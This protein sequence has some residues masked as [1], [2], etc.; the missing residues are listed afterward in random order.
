[1]NAGAYTHLNYTNGSLQELE[2]SADAHTFM[3]QTDVS[4]FNSSPSE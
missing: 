3:F 4:Y 1:M 2:T